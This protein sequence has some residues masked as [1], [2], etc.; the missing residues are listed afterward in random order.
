MGPGMENGLEKKEGLRRLVR[1]ISVLAWMSMAA[2]LAISIASF[3]GRGMGD[4]VFLIL[5]IFF[6]VFA[7]MQGVAWVVA[8]FSG[9][10]QGSDGL[11]RRP[12]K[13]RQPRVG[14]DSK[15]AVSGVGGWLLLL[16]VGL[17]IL[18]P[19]SMLGGT[20]SNIQKSE[21]LHPFLIGNENWGLYK[22]WAWINVAVVCSLSI[23]AG[24]RLFSI[25]K[26]ASVIFAVSVLWLRWGISLLIDFGTAV[27]YLEI[28]IYAYFSPQVLGQNL[29]SIIVA[30]I[31]TWYLKVSVRVRNTYK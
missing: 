13:T 11:I 27:T 20:L 31:W 2:G 3:L 7:V 8:G 14:I 1:A 12:W 30:A 6:A 10:P 29:G 23:A 25:F 18:S 5:A 16:I 4:K 26:Y 19:L 28:P 15:H 22:N 24:Y 21:S 9:L 17:A